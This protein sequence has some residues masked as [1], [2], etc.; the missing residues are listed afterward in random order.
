MGLRNLISNCDGEVHSEFLA[1]KKKKKKKAFG[2][3][4]EQSE[5]NEAYGKQIILSTDPL[6]AKC[7]L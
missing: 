3:N 2:D 6:P 4:L 1:G 7:V 5:G